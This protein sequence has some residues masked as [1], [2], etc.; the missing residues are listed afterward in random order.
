LPGNSRD[1]G[2]HFCIWRK[3]TYT[4][5]FVVLPLRNAMEHSTADGRINSVNDQATLGINLVGFWSVYPE[6]TRINSVQQASI[7]TWVSLSTSARWQHSYVLLLLARGRD[8]GAERAI[9]NNQ[10][11]HSDDDLQVAYSSW[12]VP[13]C[14]QQMQDGGRPPSRKNMINRRIF[15]TVSLIFN[16]IWYTNALTFSTQLNNHA[17]IFKTVKCEI[18][19]TVGLISMKFGMMMHINGPPDHSATKVWIFENPR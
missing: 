10:I 17:A 7:N 3:S 14:L 8:C 18:S 12:V 1:N 15:A 2:A 4:C 11:L 19:A 9:R 5:A 16:A 13:K 6:F